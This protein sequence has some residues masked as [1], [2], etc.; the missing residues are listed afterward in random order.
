MP[1]VFV[2]VGII[3]LVKEKLPFGTKG[4]TIHLAQFMEMG[5]GSEQKIKRKETQHL[6]CNLRL[7]RRSK[8]PVRLDVKQTNSLLH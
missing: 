4:L 6:S 8:E 3:F 1:L 2:T 7:Y 5:I